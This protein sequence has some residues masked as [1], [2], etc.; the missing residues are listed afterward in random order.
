MGK[1]KQS[2]PKPLTS[3]SSLDPENKGAREE[4][5]DRLDGE[6][7]V[8]TDHP[9]PPPPALVLREWIFFFF[10]ETREHLKDRPPFTPPGIHHP[11]R[12]RLG[13]PPRKSK[14]KLRAAAAAQ[15]AQQ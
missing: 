6:G 7:L 1:S 4:N 3:L 9:S 12:A 15:T 10:N 11:A 5:G 8:Q 14:R 2:L 13:R